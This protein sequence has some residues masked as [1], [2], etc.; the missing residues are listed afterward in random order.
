[1]SAWQRFAQFGLERP[2]NGRWVGAACARERR[3]DRDRPERSDLAVTFR[4]TNV[5]QATNDFRWPV[6]G[7]PLQSGQRATHSGAGASRRARPQAAQHKR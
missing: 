3:M 2:V 4:I 5:V 6:I 7:P 1:M